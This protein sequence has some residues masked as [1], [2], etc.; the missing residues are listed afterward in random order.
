VS[1]W[2]A[3]SDRA[4]LELQPRSTIGKLSMAS[5]AAWYL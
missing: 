1:R 3:N 5:K 4:H 2:V